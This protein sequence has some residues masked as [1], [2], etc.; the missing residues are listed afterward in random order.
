[1]KRPYLKVALAVLASL[2]LLAYLFK[3][4]DEPLPYNVVL[5]SIDSLRAD[6]VGAYGYQRNTTPNIDAFAKDAVI[7][8]K[9]AGEDRIV[10]S[11][12][13]DFGTLL[14]AR[15]AQKPSVIQFSAVPEAASPTR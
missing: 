11:A 9:A 14:A 6:R 13:T 12:D 1:M 5:I 2:L 10:V 7:F 4:H 8:D 15:R 3:S